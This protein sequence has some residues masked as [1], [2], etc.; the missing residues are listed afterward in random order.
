MPYFVAMWAN[1]RNAV[2][3]ISTKFR[4]TRI[5]IDFHSLHRNLAKGHFV[6]P[7]G[8][9]RCP[10]L[11]PV[12]GINNVYVVHVAIFVHV[13]VGEIHIH[14]HRL[15]SFFEKR[16]GIPVRSAI[17]CIPAIVG[18][19]LAGGVRPFDVA[20]QI[21]SSVRHIIVVVTHTSHGTVFTESGFVEQALEVI[22][23]SHKFP[24]RELHQYDQDA[25]VCETSSVV[26]TSHCGV[27]RPQG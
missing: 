12:T 1:A 10:R 8:I 5:F 25:T 7:N 11:L 2:S 24:I 23:A 4:G 17:T 13:I 26:E 14:G 20:Q 3:H 18:H 19:P 6:R 9:G 16:I 27:S 21:K 15:D 22:S